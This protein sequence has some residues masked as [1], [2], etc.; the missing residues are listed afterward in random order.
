MLSW[1]FWSKTFLSSCL[2]TALF[3]NASLKPFYRFR[4]DVLAETAVGR[5]WTNLYYDHA[6]EVTGLAL[7]NS[8]VLSQ[9]LQTLFYAVVSIPEYML[10]GKSGFMF[11][12]SLNEL[13]ELLVEE[14]SDELGTAL[15]SEKRSIFSFLGVDVLY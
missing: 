11:A 4:D 8:E 3:G 10:T 13:M 1:T 7:S 6:L 12:M 5:N 2:I 15:L 14:G 9:T